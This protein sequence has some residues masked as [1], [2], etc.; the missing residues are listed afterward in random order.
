MISE[1]I[2]ERWTLDVP[3]SENEYI[4]LHRVPNSAVVSCV[5]L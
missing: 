5:D 1:F 3:E 2:A 4:L